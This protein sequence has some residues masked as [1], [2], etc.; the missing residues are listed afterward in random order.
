MLSRAVKTWDPAGLAWHG[1]RSKARN[2]KKKN[3]T[4]NGKRPQAGQG[5]KWPKNGKIMENSLKNPFFGH[6]LLPFPAF[7]RF[8]CH[9]SPAGSQVKTAKTVM[10]ATPVFGNREWGVFQEGG[11][12][13]VERAAFSSCGNLLLQW[14]SYSKKKTLRLLLRRRV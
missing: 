9:A 14:N 8:P 10:K 11:F 2:G 1:K 5:Q 3:G 7:G 6:F 12:Q 13:I 4:P